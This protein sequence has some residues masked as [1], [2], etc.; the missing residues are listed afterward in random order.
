MSTNT[1]SLTLTS[2]LAV[3][4]AVSGMLKI[5]SIAGGAEFQL[6]APIALTIAAC[7]G[8]KRY[9]I[10][11]FIASALNLILSTHT[12]I[13]VVV[14]LVFRIMGGGLVALFGVNPITLTLGGPV[15]TGAARVVLSYILN[16]NV[17]VLL[18]AAVSGMIFTAIS[19][20]IIYPV[21]YRIVQATPYRD[22]LIPKGKGLLKFSSKPVIIEQD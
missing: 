17:W 3:L 16:A 7:F 11:G 18:T 14:S 5:P 4:I 19:T 8:F 21:V 6:S 15:G 22:M 12:I 10:A 2:M 1:K 9:I 20:N 13:N